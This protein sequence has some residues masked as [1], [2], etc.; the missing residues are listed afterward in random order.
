MVPMSYDLLYFGAFRAI[1]SIYPHDGSVAVSTGG[2]EMG[3]GLN[4]KVLIITRLLNKA[5][6]VRFRSFRL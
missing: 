4:T 5:E 1:V 6:R 2:V 3:Q